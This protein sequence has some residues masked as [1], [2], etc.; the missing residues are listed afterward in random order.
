MI[1]L[2]SGGVV[3]DLKRPR[4]AKIDNTPLLTSEK[5]INL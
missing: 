3:F 5:A 1:T 2:S 4:A